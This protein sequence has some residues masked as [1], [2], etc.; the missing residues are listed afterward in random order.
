MGITE[1]EGKLALDRKKSEKHLSFSADS[2]T[3]VTISNDRTQAGHNPK[4]REAG[5][6]R[7]TPAF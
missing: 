6:K 2:L 1:K 5:Y 4:E 3:F 7:P